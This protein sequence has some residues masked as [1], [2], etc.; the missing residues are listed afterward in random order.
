MA[1]HEKTR[2]EPAK[3]A[4]TIGPTRASSAKGPRFSWALPQGRRFGQGCILTHDPAKA[5][6]GG[7]GKGSDWPRKG[8]RDDKQERRARTEK[9][10][11]RARW[12]QC[13]KSPD[14]GGGGGDGK[15]D[16]E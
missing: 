11:P 14:G 4:R 2:P 9:G 8:S 6:Q 12:Q 13:A 3:R 7:G 5:R 10:R 16:D 15:K 1:L